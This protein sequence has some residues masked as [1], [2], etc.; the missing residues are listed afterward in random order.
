MLSF[1][2]RLLGFFGILVFFAFGCTNEGATRV[3]QDVLA[4]LGSP[5]ENAALSAKYPRFINAKNHGE[6]V[7]AVCVESRDS[8]CTKVNFLFTRRPG[9]NAEV[10][11]SEPL[12][13][14]FLPEIIREM[15][16]PTYVTA[17]G[18]VLE[19]FN[20]NWGDASEVTKLALGPFLFVIAAFAFITEPIT[21]LPYR[22]P[23]YLGDKAQKF[24]RDR[25]LNRAT[26]EG[27]DAY[28]L[29]E[30]ALYKMRNTA[31]RMKNRSPSEVALH[32][33]QSL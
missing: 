13:V 8:K 27:P 31:K 7:Y 12:E 30:W 23:E 28:L 26:Q 5:E 11:N 3:K 10:L 15:D 19:G 25:R 20:D 6:S 18:N 9:A 1:V 24:F 4:S 14:R 29:P 16:Q 32:C 17:I 21:A 2:P 33:G 22:L